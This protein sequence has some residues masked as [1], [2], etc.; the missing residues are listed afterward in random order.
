MHLSC[1]TS[2]WQRRRESGA[3]ARRLWPLHYTRAR[4]RARP[5][6]HTPHVGLIGRTQRLRAQV[7]AARAPGLQPFHGPGGHAAA[8]GASQIE[9]ETSAGEA[10]PAADAA[11]ATGG[12]APAANTDDATQPGS[13]PAPLWIVEAARCALPAGEFRVF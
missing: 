10:A 4:A 13:A 7:A 8:A 1:S 9:A 5:H 3:S 12:G 6:A 2:R 11:D